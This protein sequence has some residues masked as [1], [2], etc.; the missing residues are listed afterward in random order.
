MRSSRCGRRVVDVSIMRLELLGVTAGQISRA[1]FSQRKKNCRTCPSLAQLR[2]SRSRPARLSPAS[3]WLGA[4]CERWCSPHSLT[5]NFDDD[6]FS[7][8]SSLFLLRNAKRP[9]RN[10]GP[11]AIAQC[12]GDRQ[13]LC[14]Q[15]TFA[16]KYQ[17]GG[18][19]KRAQRS[20]CCVRP[21][22]QGL[23]CL[24]DL[25]AARCKDETAFCSRP[26]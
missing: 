1:S 3:R 22:K 9:R 11:G 15:H 12:R 10:L 21:V 20:L 4:R 7:P 26:T 16:E 5:F 24:P 25:Y 17:C 18:A 14:R 8:A 23:G 13:N 6:G 2:P 19:G